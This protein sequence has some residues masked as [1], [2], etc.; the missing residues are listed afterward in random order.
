MATFA[1]LAGVPGATN[2]TADIA[3][4]RAPNG[5]AMDSSNNLYVADTG[6]NVIR[7]IT[8]DG[9]VSTFAGSAGKT[10]SADKTGTAAT[11]N[12]PIGVAVDKGG[13]VYVAD[14]SNDTIRKI[15]PAGV[16]STLAGLA[17]SSGTNDGTGQTARFTTPY[18]LVVDDN[19]NVYVTDTFNHTLRKITPDGVVT[20]LAG[21]AGNPGSIDDVG[22]NARFD[23]PVGIAVD[24]GTNLYVSDFANNSIRKVTMGLAVTTFAGGPGGAGSTDGTGS[25]ARFSSPGDV[26]LSPDGNIYVTDQGNSTI[27]KITSSGVVTTLAGV[28]GTPGTNDG[29]G[30]LARFNKPVGLGMGTNGNFFVADTFNHAIREVTPLGA[31]TTYAGVPGQ[32]GTV[33]GPSE[34]ARFN[35]PFDVAVDANGN[36]FVGDTHNHTIRKITPD[37]AVSTFAGSLLQQGTNDGVGTA[38]QFNF[39]EG[40]AFNQNQNLYVV[41]DGNFTIR[42]IS[43]LAEVTTFAGT[44]G[45][46]GRADGP[47][48]TATFNFPFG[49][50]VDASGNVYV[51]DVVN[52]S[53]RKITSAGVVTTIAGSAGNVGSLDGTGSDAQFNNP[54]GLAVDDQGNVYVAD[55]SNHSIRKRLSCLAG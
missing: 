41:D 44:P 26:A 46:T 47:A 45:V 51:S 35:E 52:S 37:G 30:S 48:S 31:V 14:S 2:G 36:V 7:K 3:R 53:I 17:L 13:N 16:V 11:F 21:S 40:V 25:A 10:G 50:T 55:A 38:A 28:A 24:D 23:F 34:T 15:T 12:S 18:N 29:I 33:D 42:K 32:S 49:T 43:P 9:V 8:S 6:N 5:L 54:E 22:T 27:R 39:P 20:T 1:G 4:F 19:T